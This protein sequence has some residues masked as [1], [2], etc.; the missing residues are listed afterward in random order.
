MTDCN[1][2]MRIPAPDLQ[3]FSVEVLKRLDLPEEEASIVADV[4]VAADLRGVESHGVGRLHFYVGA[5][6]QGLITRPARITVLSEWPALALLDGGASMGQVVSYRAMQKCLDMADRAGM[7]AVTVRNSKHYGIA[8]YYAMMALP[9]GMIGISLTNSRP[10]A[11]PT[12]GTKAMLGT[13]PISMAVPTG[14]ERP[15]VLD[16][17]TSTIPLGKVELA[18]RTGHALPLGVAF[19]ATGRPTTDPAA[20][21]DGGTLAPLGGMAETGGYKGYG[22]S[23]LVDVLTGVLSGAGYS[24]MFGGGWGESETAHFFAALRVDA[25]RPLGDFQAMMDALVRDLRES[26]KAAGQPRIIIHG[27]PEFEAEEKRRREGIVVVPAVAQQLR[28]MAER[29]GVRG[30]LP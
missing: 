20:M 19:D 12:F 8:A 14:R 24:A 15:W 13:N 22:L 21:L 10:H 9:R 30:I 6:E 27:E 2:E 4:L 29:F 5:L 18:Q 28:H 26:P 16:M 11:A 3:R 17:A 7:A 1:G 25:A 23:I